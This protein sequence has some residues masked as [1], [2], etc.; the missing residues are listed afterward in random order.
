MFLHIWL[1]PPPLPYHLPLLHY[2][3]T[4]SH[5]GSHMMII[6]ISITDIKQIH[7]HDHDPPPPQ[8]IL[9]VKSIFK[10]PSLNK[11][12][13]GVGKQEASGGK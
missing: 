3:P 4:A 8:L 9:I 10:G 7:D 6:I 2:D 13:G 1:L 5:S 12:P 11:Q